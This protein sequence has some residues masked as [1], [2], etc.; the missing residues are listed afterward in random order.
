MNMLLSPSPRSSPPPPVD[1]VA[2][3]QEDDDLS[4]S[5]VSWRAEG[6]S[7]PDVISALLPPHWPVL[8]ELMLTGSK[9]KI[10]FVPSRARPRNNHFS[11]GEVIER[12][13]SRHKRV[14]EELTSKL[15]ASRAQNKVLEERCFPAH[16]PAAVS[17]CGSTQ[18]LVNTVAKLRTENS[19][20]ELSLGKIV[21][22]ADERSR[23]DRERI[24]NMVLEKR[25][26]T[27]HVRLLLG[28]I[29]GDADK[30][31]RKDRERIELLEAAIGA[32]RS[33]GVE[34]TS[35]EESTVKS[36]TASESEVAEM[37][38]DVAENDSK[39]GVQ[40]W[41]ARLLTPRIEAEV[42]LAEAGPTGNLKIVETLGQ[43][44]TLV[45]PMCRTE[46]N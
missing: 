23:K 10:D 18:L 28:K 33:P 14:V 26:F 5:E 39:V 34:K 16:T 24:E 35:S 15:H 20:L 32:T 22:D 38:E 45:G 3:S 19:R 37:E 36:L 27:A 9:D 29:V 43:F 30:R 25:C 17:S 12:E 6:Y 42:T 11:E 21:G 2:I 7:D 4:T 40:N 1:V 44:Q 41:F 31:S 13:L 46:K 8:T